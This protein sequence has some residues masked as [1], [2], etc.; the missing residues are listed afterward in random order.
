MAGCQQRSN[1][2]V[3]VCGWVSEVLQERLSSG[4]A[5]Q[6]AQ[7]KGSDGKGEG[8]SWSKKRMCVP[9]EVSPVGY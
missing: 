1:T 6:Q 9:Q 8:W 5:Q 3:E 2:S 4:A 7:R